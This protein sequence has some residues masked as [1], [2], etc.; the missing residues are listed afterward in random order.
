[1]LLAAARALAGVVSDDELNPAYI[2]PSVFNPAVHSAVATAV[3]RAAGGPV[4]LPA[5]PEAVL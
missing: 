3:R 1:M 4:E 2:T 5:D